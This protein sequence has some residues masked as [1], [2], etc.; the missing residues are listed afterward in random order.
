[1]TQPPENSVNRYSGD[2]DIPVGN[3][4]LDRS[5]LRFDIGHVVPIRRRTWLGGVAAAGATTAATLAVGGGQAP[6]FAAA[7]GRPGAESGW[8]TWRGPNGNNIAATDAFKQTVLSRENVAWQTPVPG[9]GHS[10]PIVTDDAIYLTTADT[11]AGTQSLL[12]FERRNGKALWN[13]T[14]HRGGLPKENHRKNTEASST[15][16]FDGQRVIATFYNSDALWVSAYAPDG[17]LVWQKSMGRYYPDRF[18]YGYAASPAIYNDTAVIIGEFDGPAFMTAIAL[19]TGE[20]VWR[21]ERPNSTSFSSPIVANV[22]GR[23]QLLVSGQSHVTSYNP[24]SGELL[25]S[26]PGTAMATCGTV[27]WDKQ[28]VYA[29]GGFPQSQTVAVRADGSNQVVWQN[30]QKCYEQ[31][32]LCH[33]GHVYAVTDQGV[34]YCWRCTDGEVM[35]RERLGGNYSSSPIL[36][37]NTIHVF[38]EAC[39]AFAFE[40]NPRMFFSR[41]RGKLG[42]EAF[43]TPSVVG[44]T[45]YMR[46]A[47]NEG[48]TRQEYL[49][50]IR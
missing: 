7:G 41:G 16:A 12:A 15:V 31:S 2:D 9:R 5:Q 50:A 44:N 39:E 48:T 49:L 3:A 32:M 14:V 23:D 33:D 4:K 1:M 47:R 42:D 6:A 30:G 35:W 22:G 20:A 11:K 18:K 43:A 13:Q 17:K 29:S 46:I 21:I 24:A 40:A 8:W 37:G 45:M 28:N 25:W 26:A 34:A 27:V 38:N 10:S 19:E 36:V